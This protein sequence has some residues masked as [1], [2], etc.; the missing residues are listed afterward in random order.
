VTILRLHIP[1]EL[2]AAS[3]III[4]E[5]HSHV[6]VAVE[7]SKATLAEHER[8][9]RMLLEAARPPCTGDTMEDE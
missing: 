7:I 6:V 2:P 5:S 8:F 3:P 9:L 1:A 4:S